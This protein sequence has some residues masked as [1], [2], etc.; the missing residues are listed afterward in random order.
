MAKLIYNKTK[1]HGNPSTP[2]SG[3][4]VDKIKVSVPSG[5]KFSHLKISAAS[6]HSGAATFTVTKAP[7]AN[8]SG[9]IETK[10]M[11]TNGP[12]SKC[13]YKLRVYSKV[14]QPG[15]PPPTPKPV[16]VFGSPNWYNLTTGYITQKIP[17]RL[18]VEGPD[19]MK[20][21]NII[22]PINTHLVMR[23][24]VI[25][26]PAT[27][28]IT[29]IIC[30]T[31]LGVVGLAVVGGVLLYAINQG[32]TTTAIYNTDISLSGNLAQA[33]EFDFDNCGA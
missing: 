14:Q 33:M 6:G 1:S 5:Q 26:E 13:S 19:A 9:N 28:V 20:L 32:C 17:F 23:R 21:V 2:A 12:W 8:A 29:G 31:I 10:V 4:G 27:I 25:N 15:T 24:I 11:W 22:N 16:V 30:L 7:K 3:A 18:R